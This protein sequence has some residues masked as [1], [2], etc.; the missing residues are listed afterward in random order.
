[1]LASMQGHKKIDVV[2]D[3]WAVEI[4]RARIYRSGGYQADE[5]P[6]LVFYVEK[7]GKFSIDGDHMKSIAASIGQSLFGAFLRKVIK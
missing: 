6:L 3:W 1:M 5:A 2:I 4:V 7:D